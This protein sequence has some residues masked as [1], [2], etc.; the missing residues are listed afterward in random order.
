MLPEGRAAA[1][2]VSALVRVF[3][4]LEFSAG[5]YKDKVI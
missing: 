5:H 4:N 1:L 2:T 3:E